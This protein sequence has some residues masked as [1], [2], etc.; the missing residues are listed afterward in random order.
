MNSMFS[1]WLDLV[2]ALGLIVALSFVYA[3]LQRW[4]GFPVLGHAMLGISFGLVAA[5]EM[6]HPI[7]PFDG[8]IVDLR[9]APIAL[10]GAFL[11]GPASIVALIIGMFAR[12]SIGG[13][14]MWSGMLGMVFAWA[15]GRIWAYWFRHPGS[16]GF[17]SYCALGLMMSSHMLAALILPFDMMVW[18]YTNAAISLFVL[19]M[20]TV[21]MLASILETERR[22]Y[23]TEQALRASA[24][25]DRDTGLLP[26][27]A[28]QRECAIRA[29]ALAD[30]SFTQA[31][32]IRIENDH[33]FSFWGAAPVRKRLVAAMRMRLSEALP[34]CDLASV[35]GT[36]VLI[37]P[38]TQMDMLT[39]ADT[40]TIVRRAATEELYLVGGTL[41]HRI[42]VSLLIIDLKPE[43]TF[44]EMLNGI[45][46]PS[47]HWG[48]RALKQRFRRQKAT[49]T[50]TVP[51]ADTAEPQVE[52]MFA[53]ADFL[54]RQNGRRS[55]RSG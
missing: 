28:L 1:A 30:G 18:F 39:P 15:A 42:A 4:A 2:A 25:L 6:N 54:M 27:Q 49:P 7:Q 52:C 29:T 19:N 45:G 9:N 3:R 43:A 5:V 16:R 17:Q 20:I 10:A 24:V 23:G 40:K 53:K 22:S 48:D 55:A 44:L 37:L 32:V 26:L 34:H 33:L 50:G 12:A 47:M 14:G 35:H 51:I 13:V 46:R 38:I 41:G 8:M 36:S 11:N 31:V 21:P